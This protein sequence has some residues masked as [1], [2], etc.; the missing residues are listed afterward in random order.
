MLHTIFQNSPDN[1]DAGKVSLVT[2][3]SQQPTQQ[4]QQQQHKP[5]S[6]T[7]SS[8]NKIGIL[9]PNPRNKHYT[10][11]NSGTNVHNKNNP[12]TRPYINQNHR[13]RTNHKIYHNN[14]DSDTK[15]YNNNNN[16][17]RHHDRTN[18][19]LYHN[20]QDSERPSHQTYPSS[21]SRPNR[22]GRPYFMLRPTDKN[23]HQPQKHQSTGSAGSTSG[24]FPTSHQMVKKKYKYGLRRGLPAGNVN[25]N[26]NSFSNNIYEPQ[27]KPWF[28]FTAPPRYTSATATTAIAATTTTTVAPPTTTTL[29]LLHS[30]DIDPFGPEDAVTDVLRNELL[31]EFIRDR[32]GSVT[33]EEKRSLT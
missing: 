22:P 13:D 24:H 4:Q 31:F 2:I 5:S 17:H 3:G 12:N 19:N 8:S 26:Y 11:N 14:Q 29:G 18:S 9:V 15:P 27:H 10:L 6:A 21:S 32:Q 30:K 23:Q 33:E 25:N 20:N 7:T 16:N 28:A 1:G